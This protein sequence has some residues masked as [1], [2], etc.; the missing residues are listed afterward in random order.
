[1][2]ALLADNSDFIIIPQ[3]ISEE[4]L[5]TL[6]YYEL[7]VKKNL[8]L[9]P[10]D[11]I[12]MH[13]G[14]FARVVPW[15]W[16]KAIFNELFS[17]GTP[18]H[19][20]PSPLRMEN[21]RNLSHRKTTIEFRK[22]IGKILREPVLNL[23]EQLFSTEEVEVFLSK[24]N[25]AYFKSPWSSS[26]RGIVVSD[27]IS[28]KGLMEWA[29]GT[30]KKQGSV[31][32]EPAWPRIF[33]FASEWWVTHNNA[34]FVGYSVFETSSRGKYHKNIEGNQNE[35]LDMIMEKVPNFSPKILQAQ[36]ETI[37][38]LISPSYSGPLGIDMLA[39]YEGKI[40]PCVEL[41]L[42]FTMGFLNLETAGYLHLLDNR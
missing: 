2:P 24:H 41:N 38:E 28:H 21:I 6:P 17:N 11:E 13:V 8:N 27:H 25:P 5:R 18:L 33:D 12:P 14:K 4:E 40:N 37:L 31:I 15:G 32:G 26:G 1:M 29:H 36:K 20:L 42:R 3:N 35:L 30:I 10:L 16:D 39:D 19:L 9:I 7:A 34:I 23:P 22:N